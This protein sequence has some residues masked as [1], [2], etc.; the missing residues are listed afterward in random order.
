MLTTIS[1]NQIIFWINSIPVTCCAL[2][3]SI[4]DLRDGDILIA[5]ICS[6]LQIKSM[7]SIEAETTVTGCVLLSIP[8][9]AFS[10]M[11]VSIK[12]CLEHKHITVG[13]L[14]NSERRV[15][16][17]TCFQLISSCDESTLKTGATIESK[18]RVA[19]HSTRSLV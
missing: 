18:L 1:K 10:P 8:D 3:E 5:L 12:S 17:Y 13:V 19:Q 11:I 15:Y 2:F 7:P 16:S 6:I 9:F 4:A 14:Y